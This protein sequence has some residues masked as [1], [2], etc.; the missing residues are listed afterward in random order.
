MLSKKKKRKRN[1]NSSLVHHTETN[2][3]GLV[4]KSVDWFLYNRQ[5]L[6]GNGG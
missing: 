4:R 6:Q 1:K 3:T 5:T 2:Q